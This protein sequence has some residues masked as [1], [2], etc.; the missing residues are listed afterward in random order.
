MTAL[1]DENVGRLDVAMDNALGVRG[2]ERVR[3][4][5]ASGQQRSISSGCPRSECFRVVAFEV[6][7][8]DEGLLVLLRRCRGWC[9]CW[10][11]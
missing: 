10:D 5:M 11:G 9:R 6:F 8:D 2:V 1:R 4:S 7:H 3:D